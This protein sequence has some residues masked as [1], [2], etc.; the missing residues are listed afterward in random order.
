MGVSANDE[1]TTVVRV[2]EGV[3]MVLVPAGC[4]PMGN[5]DGFDEEQPVHQVCLDRPFWIDLTEVT[6]AQFTQFLN[7]QDEPV[8]DVEGWLDR[9]NDL[10]PLLDQLTLKDRGWAPVGGHGNRPLQS[11][12]RV[13]ADAYCT[14][15]GARLPTEAEWEYAARGP[16]GLLYPW[17]NTFSADKVVRVHERARMPEAGSKPTGASWVG[18]L[19]LSSSLFEWVSSLY[20]PYPYDPTDGREAGLDLDDS[21]DRVL[22][23]TAWYHPDGMHDNLC[24]TARI[25]VP[26][27]HA[28]WYFGFRC[29]RGV[30]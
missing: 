25:N 20:W 1:W 21:S 6:V 18:A 14:W 23:G 22:R 24:A 9:S 8:F 10:A 12:T 27:H 15:R 19:D 2:F 30:D 26:P 5:D 29:A 11:V 17:G 4:F 3:S 13:G 28:V 16:D 7:R